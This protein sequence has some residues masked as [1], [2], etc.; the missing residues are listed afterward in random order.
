MTQP[1]SNR[2]QHPSNRFRN[3]PTLAHIRAFT[4]SRR[5]TLVCQDRTCKTT[6][7]NEFPLRSRHSY[8]VSDH[9]E[10]DGLRGVADR[11]LF[12]GEAEEKDVTCTAGRGIS[13]QGTE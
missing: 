3:I 6:S 9:D 1:R 10:F 13:M 12:F 4:C 5:R 2:P 7:S 8:V 11:V